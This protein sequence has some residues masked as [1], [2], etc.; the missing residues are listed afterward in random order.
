MG[1]QLP[2]AAGTPFS[3]MLTALVSPGVG[4]STDVGPAVY[5][6]VPKVH[7]RPYVVPS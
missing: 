3:S 6:P 2:G 1:C 7:V 5:A 4:G